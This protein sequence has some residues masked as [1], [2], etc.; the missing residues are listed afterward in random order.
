[1]SFLCHMGFSRVLAAGVPLARSVVFAAWTVE[2]SGLLGSEAYANDPVYPLEKTVVNL[3]LDI[4]QTAGLARD[5]I[6]VDEGQSDLQDDLAS[7]ARRTGTGDH[8]YRRRCGSAQG[9]TRSGRSVG[10]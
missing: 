9:R 4:L 3:T 5:V 1:M 6:L 8:R 2:D 10:C 7:A